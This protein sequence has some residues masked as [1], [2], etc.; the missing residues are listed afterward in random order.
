LGNVCCQNLS[1][2]LLLYKNIHK[3]RT[4]PAHREEHGLGMVETRVLRRVC[5][6]RR[7]E[8]MREWKIVCK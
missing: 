1:P 6:P 8:V 2:V 4:D 5:G 3:L 7:E